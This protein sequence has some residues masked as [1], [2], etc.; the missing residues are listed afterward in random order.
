MPN[1]LTIVPTIMLV[2][3]STLL[4]FVT[5]SSNNKINRLTSQIDVLNTQIDELNSSYAALYSTIDTSQYLIDL[6]PKDNH[7]PLNPIDSFFAE[8]E[9][10]VD[11]HNTTWS[12]VTNGVVVA[13]AWKTEMEHFYELLISRTQNNFV[14]E[15]L[16]NEIHHYMEY[17]Q[18]F[19]EMHAMLY[20][21]NAFLD[22]EDGLFWGSF[23]AVS[24]SWTIA[25][26]Y[27]SKA[28]DLLDRLQ[29][30]DSSHQINSNSTDFSYFIFNTEDFLEWMKENYPEL[31][32][33]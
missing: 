24:H 14:R 33:R 29:R 18:N 23:S 2:I 31:W 17:I 9:Q 26:G 30:L 11:F 10:E 28:L 7:M 13:A 3:I 4:I 6:F 15:T 27:R 16:H 8:I 1:K 32:R 12:M 22:D 19:A 25:Q 5:I 21:S 20:A